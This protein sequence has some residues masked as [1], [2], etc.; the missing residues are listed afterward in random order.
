MGK[1]NL[2]KKRSFWDRYYAK[3]LQ[4]GLNWQI[5]SVSEFTWSLPYRLYCCSVAA[6]NSSL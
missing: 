3:Y 2:K 5:T 6:C 1:D 4:I